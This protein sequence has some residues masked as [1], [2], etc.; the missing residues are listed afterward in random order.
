[1]KIL[2]GIPTLVAMLCLVLVL[3]YRPAGY[4]IIV[5]AIVGAYVFGGTI[6]WIVWHRAKKQRELQKH[7]RTEGL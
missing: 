7:A 4:G 3:W 1:M 5:F 6:L 2:R